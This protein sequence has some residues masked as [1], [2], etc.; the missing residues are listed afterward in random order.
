MLQHFLRATQQPSAGNIEYVGGQTQV[1]GTG[2]T[3][4]TFALTGGLASTPADGDVVIV[5]VAVSSNTDYAIGVVTGGYAEI[6]ELYANATRD[7]NLSVSWKRMGGSPDTS[8]VVSGKSTSSAAGSVVVQV[9]RGVD[10]TQPF[11]VTSTT[12]TTLT[13]IKPDPASIT[14]T[15]SGAI[16][17]VAAATGSSN[18]SGTM[19][20]SYLSDFITGTDTATFYK[21]YASMGNVAWTSGSYDPAQFTFSGT[22]NTGYTSASV[23]MALRPA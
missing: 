8:V 16:I 12:S 14:P 1:L 6:S 22:D 7:T 2:D 18:I 17:V 11:D 4:V 9:Y 5:S 15:T 10:A 21:T 23:T 13:S 20:A 19:S 3:T